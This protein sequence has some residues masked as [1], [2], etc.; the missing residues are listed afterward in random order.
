V[1]VGIFSVPTGW[2][3]VAKRTSALERAGGTGIVYIDDI[4]HGRAASAQ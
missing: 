3:S 2:N 1:N 4:V